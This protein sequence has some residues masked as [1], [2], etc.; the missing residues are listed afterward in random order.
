MTDITIALIIT[1]TTTKNN[2]A[3]DFAL[4]KTSLE[5]HNEYYNFQLG[6]RQFNEKLI[7]SNEFEVMTNFSQNQY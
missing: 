3:G 7:F 4:K 6:L 2:N 1:Y 5:F